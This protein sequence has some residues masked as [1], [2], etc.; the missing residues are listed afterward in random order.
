MSGHISC[1]LAHYLSMYY[2]DACPSVGVRRNV[3]A[4]C[5][6]G[7][8]KAVVQLIATVAKHE[9]ASV[10]WPELFEFIQQYT[11]SNLP[12]QREVSL[13]GHMWSI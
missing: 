9:L 10:K 7:V 6:K 4:I 12:E 8:R 5:R 1:P 2:D 11:H 13:T 3:T